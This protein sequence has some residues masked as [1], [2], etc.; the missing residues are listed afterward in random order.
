MK[1]KLHKKW[2]GLLLLFV[3]LASAAQNKQT[4]SGFVKDRTNGEGLIGVSVYVRE[5]QTGVVTNPYG[6]YSITLP[7][8]SYTVVYSYIGYQKVIKT[9]EL[10]WKCQM[11]AKTFRKSPFLPRKKTTTY[12]ALKCRSTRLK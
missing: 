8:G 4:I 7:A 5:A 1:S 3:S 12:A 2:I 9:V 6:F 10:T 11:K